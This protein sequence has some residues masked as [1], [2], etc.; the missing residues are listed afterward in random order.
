MM[1]RGSRRAVPLVLLLAFL[2]LNAYGADFFNGR[3]KLSLNE[4]T[5]R[6]SL[7]YL[8]DPGLNR[9]EPLFSDQ[10]PRST[11]L[12]VMLNEKTYRL[13][14]TSFFTTRLGGSPS[15][16]VFIFESPLM[17]ITE[18]FTFCS[19][20][21]SSEANGIQISVKLESRAGLAAGK[22]NTAGLKFLIDTKLGEGNMP[23]ADHF[24]TDKRAIG[25]EMLLDYR[26]DDRWWISRSGSSGSGL[27]G[28]ISSAYSTRADSVHFANWKR[29]NDAPWELQFN[30]RNFNNPPYSVND[31]A[32][33]YLF[34]PV[35]IAGGE[36]RTIVI[37][38]AAED[39]SG[40]TQVRLN[41][42]PENPKTATANP[43]RQK[44]EYAEPY[45]LNSRGANS[46]ERIRSDIEILRN[47]LSRLDT[48]AAGRIAISDD[49]LNAI[50]LVVNRIKTRYGLW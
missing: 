35:T 43:L 15:R 45:P 25:S 13:G 38:L 50:E 20:G 12:T 34:N 33:S 48:Y 11:S 32:V 36:S 21:A 28:S 7:Y 44:P 41:T 18:E 40:F 1:H 16:P 29:L 22:A 46:E 42:P 37:L 30:R 31:S 6:F 3:V 39:I 27:M 9:F 4:N 26:S 5:G 14:E 49:D 19:T 2:G 10:D 47:L 17:T 23:S 24:V 8:S